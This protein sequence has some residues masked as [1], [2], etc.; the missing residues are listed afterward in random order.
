MRTCHRY[1]HARFS[2]FVCGAGRGAGRSVPI[3]EKPIGG[4]PR[5]I[6]CGLSSFVSLETGL[7]LRVGRWKFLMLSSA[8]LRVRTD[9]YMIRIVP[10]ERVAHMRL[11]GRAA[12]VRIGNSTSA[13]GRPPETGRGDPAPSMRHHTPANT[14][15]TQHRG[16]VRTGLSRKSVSKKWPLRLAQLPEYLM[17]VGDK[18]QHTAGVCKQQPQHPDRT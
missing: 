16:T 8:S 5:C 1:I 13:P 17:S 3:A 12:H 18:P 9:D 10:R 2:S 11:C 4:S 14:E 7:C 15:P 6:S